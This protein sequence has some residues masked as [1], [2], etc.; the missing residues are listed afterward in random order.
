MLH[1]VPKPDASGTQAVGRVGHFGIGWDMP[2][3]M[4]ILGVIVIGAA[5]AALVARDNAR[6][7]YK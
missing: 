4:V 6:Y 2:I 3:L 5:V 1:A 7:I